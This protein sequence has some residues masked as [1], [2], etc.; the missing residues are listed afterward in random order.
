LYCKKVFFVIYFKDFLIEEKK[1]LEKISFLS[2]K[3]IIIIIEEKCLMKPMKAWP[4][5][6]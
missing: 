4:L 2:T 6:T 5:L 1:F 3:I